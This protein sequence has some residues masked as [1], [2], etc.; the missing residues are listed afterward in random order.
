MSQ[1]KKH[2][3]QDLSSARELK[4]RV[5]QGG[6]APS[7]SSSGSDL[8]P[9]EKHRIEDILARHANAAGPVPSRKEEVP[10]EESAA[11]TDLP[12]EESGQTDTEPTDDTETASEEKSFGEEPEAA[13]EPDEPAE[14]DVPPTHRST[15]SRIARARMARMASPAG[16]PSRS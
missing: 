3:H 13:E 1:K 2:R 11:G 15:A 4:S 6:L 12:W 9:E 8:S 5:A 7:G 14:P 10:G 16:R